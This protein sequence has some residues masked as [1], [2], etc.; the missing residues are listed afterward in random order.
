MTRSPILTACASA[1]LLVGV[2][3][4]AACSYRFCYPGILPFEGGT[5]DADV[6]VHV[7]SDWRWSAEKLAISGSVEL[8]GPDGPVPFD[9]VVS[10]QGAEAF[11]VRPRELLDDGDYTVIVHHLDALEDSTA[12]HYVG[13][14]GPSSGATESHFTVGGTPRLL[15]VLEASGRPAL[16]FSEAVDPESLDGRVFVGGFAV[17]PEAASSRATVWYVDVPE[18]EPNDLRIDPGITTPDGE[19][20]STPSEPRSVP[21]PIER[22]LGT[23]WCDP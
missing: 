19:V 2:G 8:L 22:Y 15:G 14:Y 13:E 16:V 21:G 23:T 11:E 17:T 7:R 9:V 4:L 3:L 6:V 20:F 12:G 1:A 5:A 18:E 10:G